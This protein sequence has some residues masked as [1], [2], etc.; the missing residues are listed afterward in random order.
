MARRSIGIGSLPLTRT[1]LWCGIDYDGDPRSSYCS[2]LC[3][4]RAKTARINSNPEQL[5]KRLASKRAADAARYERDSDK[6][7]AASRDYYERNKGGL[8]E[9]ARNYYYENRER[10]LE[11]KARWQKDNPE[12][13]KLSVRRGGHR[14]RAK[15]RGSTIAQISQGQFDAKALYWGNKCWM[16]GSKEWGEWDHVKPISKGGPNVLANLRPS[17]V[18]CNRSKSAKWLGPKW[19]QGMTWFS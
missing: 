11:R 17:C 18:R 15:K 7:N 9:Y 5:A 4:G 10:S 14:Y 13:H 2:K 8:R 1:C 12:R 3:K 6:R 19:A 16:C